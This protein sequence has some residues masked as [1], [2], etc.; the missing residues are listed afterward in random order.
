MQ[1]DVTPFWVGGIDLLSRRTPLILQGVTTES[2]RFCLHMLLR[3][4]AEVRMQVMRADSNLL[5]W[6]MHS[7]PIVLE[8]SVH[9]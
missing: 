4:R 8:E 9:G 6:T 1:G 2:F 3:E 5:L 7:T